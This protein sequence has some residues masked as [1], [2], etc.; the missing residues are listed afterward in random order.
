MR[1]SSNG[2]VERVL[3]RT[4]FPQKYDALKAF[5]TSEYS[6]Q[7]TQTDRVKVIHEVISM[8]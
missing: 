2:T 7:M 8:H 5:I 6:S 1:R 4:T 3:T